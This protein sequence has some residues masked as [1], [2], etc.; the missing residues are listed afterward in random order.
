M[1]HVWR[2]HTSRVAP[3]E[4]AHTYCWAIRGYAIDW[5]DSRTASTDVTV[6]RCKLTQQFLINLS[7]SLLNIN[8]L[9]AYTIFNRNQGAV[10]FRGSTGIHH[11]CAFY[12]DSA[13]SFMDMPAN[14][15]VKTSKESG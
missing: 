15:Q 13:S 5:R 10:S 7:Q 4:D 8:E 14:Y 9:C 3:L 2:S 12:A 1:I 6:V 11:A